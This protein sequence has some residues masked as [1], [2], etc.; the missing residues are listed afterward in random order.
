M[1]RNSK[2]L[3]RRRS[4][5]H[6]DDHPPSQRHS[7]I[8][9]AEMLRYQLTHPQILAALAAGGHGAKVLVSDGHYPH[10]TGAAW[11]ATVVHLN[12]APDRPLVTE[13]LEVLLDAVAVEAAT[14]MSPPENVATPPIFEEFR[15][16]LPDDVPLTRLDR[17]TFYDAARANDVILL[18]A[19][20]DRRTYAN[21][22]VT[23]G[24]S[25]H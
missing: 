25:P 8:D 16:L 14:V 13:V 6:P 10:S 9:V 5:Y 12:F 3:T 17:F 2:C 19:T 1:G 21:I 22:M 23:L 7:P 11:R 4:R 18:I 20:G 24:V 15:S